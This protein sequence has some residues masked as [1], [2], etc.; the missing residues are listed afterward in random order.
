MHERWYTWP[1]LMS[2]CAGAA[3]G[4]ARG[5]RG[6]E[7]VS[8]RDDD[9]RRS[10]RRR[11]GRAR[12]MREGGREGWA[13]RGG[14]DGGPRE[15]GTPT[16]RSGASPGGIARERA[17]G[18]ATHHALLPRGFHAHA[19]LRHRG[20]RPDARASDDLAPTR[21]RP[22][23]AT[24]WGGATSRRIFRGRSKRPGCQLSCII[25]R[26]HARNKCAE[27][28]DRHSRA[29][30]AVAPPPPPSLPPPLPGRSL[31]R[32]RRAPSPP[33][34]PTGAPSPP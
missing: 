27:T 21:R 2:A 33:A 8:A 24:S 30:S 4:G 19:A 31:V 32:S 7:T 28:T 3:R 12:E 16:V 26:F 11:R 20:A 14:R 13:S 17:R 15:M 9:G 22:M 29:R 10:A 5:R 1:Q 34:R 23:R 18:D 6:G 25:V